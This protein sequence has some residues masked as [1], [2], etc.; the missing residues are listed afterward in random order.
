MNTNSSSCERVG[1]LMHSIYDPET[2]LAPARAA[3]R[4]RL[5]EAG[6]HCAG[7]QRDENMISDIAEV[8][9]KSGQS[10]LLQRDARYKRRRAGL[11]ETG[12]ARVRAE[13]ELGSKAAPEGVRNSV[14]DQLETHMEL[15][16]DMRA[17]DRDT[18]APAE[19][20]PQTKESLA[21]A[22]LGGIVTS[23]PAFVKSGRNGQRVGAVS[24]ERARLV[25]WLASDEGQQWKR[26]REALWDLE[27]KKAL[28]VFHPSLLQA[29]G[30]RLIHLILHLLRL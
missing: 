13:A 22:V 17:M 8:M 14:S 20:D 12:P 26:Q 21:R 19:L 10:P 28:V 15:I 18:H 7:S 27:K 30:G 3:H 9:L 23:L 16:D 2:G 6:V 4:V 29:S 1:S 5:R 25:D 24:T 11:P